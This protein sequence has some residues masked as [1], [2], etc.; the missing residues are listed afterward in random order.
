MDIVSNEIREI[1]DDVI[2]KYIDYD[3]FEM[4]NLNLKHYLV[5]N[6][7]VGEKIKL[8]NNIKGR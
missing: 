4:T 7:K 3:A 2:T 8:D 5:K 6:T 1:I